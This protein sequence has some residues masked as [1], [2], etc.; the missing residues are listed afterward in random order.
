[1][2]PHW[3]AELAEPFEEMF[4]LEDHASI[5]A[6]GDSLRR[7]LPGRAITVFGVEGWPA[8][9]TATD[10]LGFH[11]LHGSSPAGRIAAA[12]SAEGP[13]NDRGARSDGGWALRRI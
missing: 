4:V 11:R 3:V 9:A 12:L 13:R 2:T 6:L 10:A 7:E 5:G 1:V 8:C